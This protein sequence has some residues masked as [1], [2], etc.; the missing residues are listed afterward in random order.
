[1]MP[2]SLRYLVLRAVALPHILQFAPIF[3]AA[4]DASTREILTRAWTRVAVAITNAIRTT[5]SDAA[6]L[7]AGLRSLEYH[8]QESG[9]RLQARLWRLRDGYDFLWTPLTQATGIRRG[10]MTASGHRLTHTR[11]RLT[12]TWRASLLPVPPLR[13]RRSLPQYHTVSVAQLATAA[14][15]T[16]FL[17]S[18][19]FEGKQVTKKHRNDPSEYRQFNALQLTRSSSATVELWTDGSVT[20]SEE[21][22]GAYV[23]AQDGQEVLNGSTSLG[24]TACSYSMERAALLT[25]LEALVT[26]LHKDA[27]PLP[28]VRV[29][30]DSLSTLQELERGP[31]H[32][33][34][35]QMEGIWRQLAYLPAAKILFVFVFSHTEEDPPPVTGDDAPMKFNIRADVLAG[36]AS[37][38]LSLLPPWPTHQRA[39][40]EGRR[41]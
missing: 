26:H 23:I 21:S 20:P 41:G 17:T 31:F 27:T 34:E 5:R 9:H 7:E 22:G 14:T 6:I 35:E 33:E 25:G 36:A 30:T 11:G 15:R 4:S 19:T 8:V 28:T 18:L 16:T 24:S 38:S 2:P 13:Q 39:S 37:S 40:C 1:M 32:Q 3:W 10:D 29:V 12:Q